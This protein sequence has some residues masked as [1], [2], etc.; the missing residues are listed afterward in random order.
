MDSK[1][2]KEIAEKNLLLILKEISSSPDCDIDLKTEL[3]KFF[4]VKGRKRTWKEL[5]C[6]LEIGQHYWK[7]LKRHIIL[8]F[9]IFASFFIST[10]IIGIMF[11]FLIGVTSGIII[12]ISSIVFTKRFKN[13]LPL[14]TV[15]DLFQIYYHPYKFGYCKFEDVRSRIKEI[16]VEQLGVAP[17]DVKD[18]AQ[19]INDLGLD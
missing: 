15:A 16:I 4:P 7:N 9:A 13:V 2:T 6:Q 10:C 14:K 3:K 1:W 17:D 12:L 11:N 19:F 18:N 5:R 8:K